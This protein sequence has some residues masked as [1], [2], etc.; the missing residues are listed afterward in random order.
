MELHKALFGDPET[1]QIG[2]VQ[3]NSEMYKAW[4]ILIAFG[5]ILTAIV[6]FFAALGTGWMAFGQSIGKFI[7][8]K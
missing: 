4:S 2:I 8:G 6:V 1:G 5:K 7:R 3:M